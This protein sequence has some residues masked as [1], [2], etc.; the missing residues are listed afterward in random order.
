MAAIMSA[1]G[2]ESRDPRLANGW[3]RNCEGPEFSKLSL[4]RPVDRNSLP[5]VFKITDKLVLAVPQQQVPSSA[6]IERE[7]SNCHKIADLPFVPYLYFVIKGRWSEGRLVEDAPNIDVQRGDALDLVTVRLEQEPG[8]AISTKETEKKNLQ[9]R[10]WQRRDSSGTRDIGGLS[11]FIPKAAFG[12]TD[13]SGRRSADSGDSTVLTYKQY[14]TTPYILVL[15]DY[16]S[17]QYGGIHVYWKVVTAS[18]LYL[19]DIDR[20]VWS[21]IK[22]WNLVA[23]TND[24]PTLR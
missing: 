20:A 17:P 11:C 1:C 13:C 3:V 15:A 4:N 5:P 2:S 8:G 19:L 18:D 22:S 12:W 7:P 14:G 6:S 23:G 16:T 24:T 9:L 10:E 21:S